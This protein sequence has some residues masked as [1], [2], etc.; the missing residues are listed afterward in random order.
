MR[1]RKAG[2]VIF[3][4]G[5]LLLLPF[6]ASAEID[7]PFQTEVV[8]DSAKVE[9]AMLHMMLQNETEEYTGDGIIR[10]FDVNQAGEVLILINGKSET[11]DHINLYDKD[12]NF[13][14]SLFIKRQLGRHAI[15]AL[16]DRTDG[17]LLLRDIRYGL[18]FKIDKKGEYLETEKLVEGISAVP[19]A[20]EVDEQSE[21]TVNGIAYSLNKKHSPF[22]TPTLTMTLPNG[23]TKTIFA[24]TGRGFESRFGILF[25]LVGLPVIGGLV[26]YFKIFHPLKQEKK[27]K[28]AN[29]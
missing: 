19:A 27:Q 22:Q 28:T 14:H 21:I 18:L 2:V 23:E 26:I 9:E 7:S 10:S 4:I 25:V 5:M 13:S 29:Q 15:T 17:L 11:E 12:G 8:D 16:F 24:H 6:S 1:Y 20:R 3:V